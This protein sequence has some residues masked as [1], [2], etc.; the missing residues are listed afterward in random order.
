M[1]TKVIIINAE[2]PNRVYKVLKG[3]PVIATKLK[4]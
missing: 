4:K 1:G 3:E 2:V